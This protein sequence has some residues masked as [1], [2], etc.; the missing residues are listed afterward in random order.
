[1][2][3]ETLEEASIPVPNDPPAGATDTQKQIWQ[4]QLNDYI[5]RVAMYEQN[6]AI[7]YSIVWGQCSP[8][9][10]AKLKDLKTY[11]NMQVSRDSL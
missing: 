7:F 6:K 9:L 11:K 5:K 4:Q 10:Q 2:M 1:M 8:T 3:I